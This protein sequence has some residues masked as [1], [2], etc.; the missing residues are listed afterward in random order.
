[1]FQIDPKSHKPIYEQLIEQMV[2]FIVNGYLEADEKLPS[3][4]ELASNLM[5]NP[6][7]VQRAYHELES[8]DFIY[9][10]KGKGSFVKRQTSPLGG[11]KKNE[12]L[13]DLERLLRE[14]KFYQIKENDVVKLV[15]LIFKAEGRSEI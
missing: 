4:R 14:V 6:N 11:V 15:K 8:Q 13:E 9:T 1:M 2:K 10:V 7:T 12:I 3:V 5:L